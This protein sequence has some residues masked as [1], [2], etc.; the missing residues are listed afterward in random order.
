MESIL[1]EKCSFKNEVKAILVSIF[2]ALSGNALNVLPAAKAKD[3]WPNFNFRSG[4]IIP[5]SVRNTSAFEGFFYIRLLPMSKTRVS[6]SRGSWTQRISMTAASIGVKTQCLNL[7]RYLKFQKICRV[8]V[9]VL[10]MFRENLNELQSSVGK[11]TNRG[12][13]IAALNV[14]S[15][16]R[17]LC[18]IEH[19]S[20]GH[21]LQILG[22]SETRI[23][24]T[25][26]DPEVGLEGFEIHR[27]DRNVNGCGVA[28]YINFRISHNRRYDID[29]PLLEAV[30]VEITPNSC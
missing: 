28:I 7:I 13:R 19:V 30:A 23:S 8:L 27:K 21:K 15:L 12:S 22:L 26:K 4:M 11:R 24:E 20:N 17:Y 29:D 9:G 6:F 3:F 10:F 1:Y 14:V 16:R 25:V 18:E 2:L 5:F